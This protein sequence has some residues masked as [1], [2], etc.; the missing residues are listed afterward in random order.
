MSAELD[1]LAAYRGLAQYVRAEPASQRRRHADRRRRRRQGGLPAQGCAQCHGGANFT[2]SG[3]ATLR[4]VGTI[5]QPGSG[6]RLGAPLTGLDP[7]T[8][9]G[10]WETAPYLHDGSAATLAAAVQRHSG[11]AIGQTDLNLLVTYLQQIDRTEPAPTPNGA[12]I[13]T[14]PG[15]QSGTIGLPVN[16]QIVASDPDGNVL[17]FSATGLPAG[18]TIS[19][20]GGLIT[21]SPTAAA[22]TTVTVTVNDGHGGIGATTF[23]WAVNAPPV[24][25]NPGNQNGRVGVAV[26]L[27]IG[28]TDPNGD[29]L[30]YSAA[31]LPTGL[32]ISSSTGRITGTPTK[33]GNSNVT[34]TVRDGRGGTAT[35][36]FKWLI[37]KR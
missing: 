36:L 12:P 14:N 1:A 9:R 33:Q 8:L 35:A 6:K 22:T 19:T 28:A 3:A 17:T 13:V 30:S 10:V 15:G 18:L 24:V 4:D 25:T 2:E 31:G 37:A 20:T 11:V 16:L 29:T 23:S 21:G 32:T 5:R 7:P 34:V 27:Q 26:S